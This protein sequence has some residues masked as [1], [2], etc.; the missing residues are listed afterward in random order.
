MAARV[1]SVKDSCSSQLRKRVYS[2]RKVA[3]ASLFPGL[4]VLLFRGQRTLGGVP[5]LQYL[6]RYAI[7]AQ[8][9]LVGDD[10]IV[11]LLGGFVPQENPVA[12]GKISQSVRIRHRT[13]KQSSF[14]RQFFFQSFSQFRPFLP[15]S[16]PLQTTKKR[17]QKFLR[18]FFALCQRIFLKTGPVAKGYH[19]LALWPNR[20]QAP[21]PPG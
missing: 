7:V 13:S 4:G 5:D 19:L 6:I 21:V 8:V 1:S 14:L 20:K 9:H 18:T 16:S 3:P 15:K 11:S 17:A 12:V 2:T 10:H